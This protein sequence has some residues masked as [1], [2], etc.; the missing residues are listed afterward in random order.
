MTLSNSAS[1][2]HPD[3]MKTFVPTAI[4][5]L[6]LTITAAFQQSPGAAPPALPQP[7]DY[8]KNLY[9]GWNVAEDGDAR[10]EYQMIHDDLDRIKFALPE[11]ETALIGDI[12][13]AFVCLDE[14]RDQ[15][16]DDKLTD[17]SNA[18]AKLGRYYWAHRDQLAATPDSELAKSFKNLNRFADD[19]ETSPLEYLDGRLLG[20]IVQTYV[21]RYANMPEYN[22]PMPQ[23]AKDALID[24]LEI[25]YPAR[26][27]NAY[28]AEHSTYVFIFATMKA[29][30]FALMDLLPQET[31][32]VILS[33]LRNALEERP[34]D[35]ETMKP[36]GPPIN[37][38]QFQ[39]A[40][41]ALAEGL[42]R[43]AISL[44]PMEP[45]P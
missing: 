22:I 33:E 26:P 34:F 20:E 11:S 12:A 41:T 32:K 39:A 3:I 27:G 38:P 29:E 15:L 40:R 24:L 35:P 19:P 6:V 44:P 23:R 25:S 42:A 2:H 1:T 18:C 4:K 21:Y 28:M 14:M 36:T 13:L 9:S 7:Y 45:M 8:L 43:F 5:V 10:T 30:A 31:R 16:R 37:S 17:L